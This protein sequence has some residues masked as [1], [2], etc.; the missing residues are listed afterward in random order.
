MGKEAYATIRIKFAQNQYIEPGEKLNVANFAK[1]DLQHLY[2]IGGI[3]L[4]DVPEPE[5][6]KGP[7]TSIKAEEPKETD[8]KKKA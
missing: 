8:T 4:R 2:D 6:V 3:E 7:D 5:P 1:E